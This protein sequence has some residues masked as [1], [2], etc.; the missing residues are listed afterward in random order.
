M[1]RAFDS[2]DTV[3]IGLSSDELARKLGKT[4]DHDFGSRKSKLEQFLKAEYPNRDFQISCLHEAF[5]P[6]IFSSKI[7]AL[8]VSEE[9]LGNVAVANEKRKK[10]GLDALHLEIVSIVKS[11]DG[12]KISSTRIRAGEIDIEGRPK[13]NSN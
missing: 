6:Q 7:G 2:A 12:G 13:G 9:T 1:K 5:G 11:Q 10:L 8:V 3:Y 4:I